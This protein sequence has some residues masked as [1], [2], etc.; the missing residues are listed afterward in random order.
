MGERTPGRPV[1]MYS[2]V[3]RTV[4]QGGWSG[5]CRFD[6]MLH[7]AFP[8]IISITRPPTDSMITFSDG[9]PVEIEPGDVVITDNHLSLDLPDRAV[10]V[11]V[12]HGCAATHY[13]RDMAWRRSGNREM[14]LQ[15]KAMLSRHGRRWVGPSSW[16][17]DE[18]SRWNPDWM[19]GMYMIPHWVDPIAPRPKPGKPIVI[20]DWRDNNKGALIWQRL[21]VACPELEFRPLDFKD[22]AG[23]R[24]QYGEASLYL[25]LS[26][27]EGGSYAMCDAEAAGLPIVTTD[28][29]NYREFSDCFE[30]GWQ[31]RGNI[32]L[33]ADAIRTKL[34]IGREK[35][36]YYATYTFEDWQAAW[37]E[38][39]E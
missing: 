27:S 3:T 5:V 13:E 20:G 37:R 25:C 22:D 29:G 33:V 6:Q 19:R 1:A 21:A 38:V 30:F 26:L 24:R 7:R 23:R 9:R 14:V 17:L 18:F 36:S 10:V 31:H 8:G 2:Y 12:H 35:P 15:Q 28:V 34:E 4:E 32:D 11:V 39:C 16:V